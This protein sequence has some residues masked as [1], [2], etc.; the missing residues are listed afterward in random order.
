M[1]RCG[2]MAAGDFPREE[3]VEEE[4]RRRV[5]KLCSSTSLPAHL[6]ASTAP[7]SQIHFS[8]AKLSHV[9]CWGAASP[10]SHRLSIGH[11]QALR[12]AHSTG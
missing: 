7:S 12:E 8:T 3:R 9:G 4:T 5:E 2:V 6:N 1:Q 11:S 10:Q